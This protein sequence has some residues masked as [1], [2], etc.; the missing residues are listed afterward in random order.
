MTSFGTVRVAAIQ[1]PPVILDV[2]GTIEKVEHLLREAADAGAQLAVL[3]ECFVSVYPSGSWA[4]S[5]VTG[6][7]G[8]EDVLVPLLSGR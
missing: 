5:D 6:H 3:P 1:A 2:E 7:Y 8:R 4:G